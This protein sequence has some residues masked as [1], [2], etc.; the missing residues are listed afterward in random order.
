MSNLTLCR[1]IS[2]QPL[3]PCPTSKN[4][5]L[6]SI[7]PLLWGG[8]CVLFSL[9]LILP[10][11]GHLM[12]LS[13]SLCWGL[14][15]IPGDCLRQSS[16]G[17]FSG[18]LSWL[19]SHSRKL[20]FIPTKTLKLWQTQPPFLWCICHQLLASPDARAHS[21]QMSGLHCPRCSPNVGHTASLCMVSLK[22]STAILREQ[23]RHPVSFPWHANYP[24]PKLSVLIA[25]LL[26]SPNMLI[27]GDGWSAECCKLIF[28][29][30]LFVIPVWCF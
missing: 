8:V 13:A 12:V 20:P 18:S 2:C 4:W 26:I 11:L 27:A 28:F 3:A 7:V 1:L 6:L 15:I 9:L 19:T 30:L 29:Q 17:W 10:R 24:F 14:F 16:I 21:S 23:D 22:P 5:D 25:F